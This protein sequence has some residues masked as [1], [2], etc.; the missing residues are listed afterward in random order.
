[1][2]GNTIYIDWYDLLDGGF[3]AATTLVSFGVVIGKTTPMQLLGLAFIEVPLW[4]LVNYIGYEIIGAIDVGK[5]TFE[6]VFEFS[7]QIFCILIGGAIFI[8]TFGA[9]FGLI[10]SLVDRQR[11]YN[12]PFAAKRSG[13]DHTTDLFSI[14]GTLMLLIYWPSFNGILA[15][16]GEGKHRAT[17]NTYL[18]LCASTMTTFLF[19]AFLGE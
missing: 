3:A 6:I 12:H 2:E 8:H 15:P 7:R 18:A 17:F 16:N 11:D 19:S 9:Y 10:V 14:L 13:S 1:M 5:Y 4:V